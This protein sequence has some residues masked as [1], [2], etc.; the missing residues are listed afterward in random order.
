MLNILC[1]CG[2]GMGT[3]TILKINVKNICQQNKIE[4]NVES[5][6]FGEAMA[7]INNT[8]IVLTSPEWA[9]MLPPS[10]AVIAETKNL[11]DTKQVTDTLVNAIKEHFPNEIGA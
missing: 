7:Y 3:S 8:D 1:V 10:N 5:C 2:N 6:S 11:I 4:A 9:G